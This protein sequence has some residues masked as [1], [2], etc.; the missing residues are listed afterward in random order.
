MHG[1]V[2]ELHALLSPWRAEQIAAPPVGR[3]LQA[4]EKMVVVHD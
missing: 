2:A 1:L 4:G 3:F